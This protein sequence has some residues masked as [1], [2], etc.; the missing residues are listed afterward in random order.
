[1]VLTFGIIFVIAAL[2]LFPLG[3]TDL[4]RFDFLVRLV[5]LGIAAWLIPDMLIQWGQ[6][7]KR[8]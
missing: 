7:S 1:M 4:S 5:A 8:L 3:S 2:L 6:A